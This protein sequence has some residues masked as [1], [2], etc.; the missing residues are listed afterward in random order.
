MARRGKDNAI[1]WDAIERQYRLGTKSNS[2]LAADFGVEVSTIGRYALR[3]GW[4][5]R[6]LPQLEDRSV[7]AD[8][9]KDDVN[10]GNVP[11]YVYVLFVHTGSEF[12]YKI[13]YAANLEA[14]LKSHQTSSPF[15]VRL[16]IGYF[17]GNMK[18][19]EAILHAMFDANR[20]RGEW[21][22]LERE[23]LE[24]IARRSLLA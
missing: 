21:F 11:G 18:A 5:P 19:E 10:R 17:V 16:A 20:V 22:R 4:P 8:Q 24:A 23:D 6:E 3:K 9:I 1:D 15:A 2:Q 13:G 12:F 14:R 7:G